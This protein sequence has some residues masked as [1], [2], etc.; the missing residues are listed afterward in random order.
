VSYPI[1]LKISKRRKS[2]ADH[3][4]ITIT[5]A[6]PEHARNTFNDPRVWTFNHEDLGDLVRKEFDAALARIVAKEAK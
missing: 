4:N 1:A 3:V 5:L 2:L 6:I